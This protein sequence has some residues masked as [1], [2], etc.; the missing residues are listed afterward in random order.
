MRKTLNEFLETL[1]NMAYS[2]KMNDKGD[3]VIVD[4]PY[5]EME[6]QVE[7]LAKQNG[8]LSSV[9]MMGG[10]DSVIIFNK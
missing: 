7:F 9:L 6:N 10:K 3:K 8:F 1:Q 5:I 4:T 2:A